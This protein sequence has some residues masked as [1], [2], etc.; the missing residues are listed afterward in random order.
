MAV[1]MVLDKKV[2]GA[3]Q[4]VAVVVPTEAAVDVAAVA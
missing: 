4:I 2:I 3:G 1:E